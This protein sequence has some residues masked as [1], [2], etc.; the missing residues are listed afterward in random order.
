MSERLVIIGGGPAGVAAAR[1]YRDNGG[2][3]EVVILSEDT[4]LPYERPPLSKDFLRGS[5]DESELSIEE[6][7][8]YTDGSIE[9]RLGVKVTALNTSDHL[10]SLVDEDLEYGGC[11]IATGAGAKTLPV[12]GASHPAIHTLRSLAD[13]RR[14]RESV[15][16]ISRVAVLGSGFIGCEIA[17]SLTHQKLEVT[18]ISDEAVPHAARLGSEVGE[19]I[20]GWLRSEG[21]RLVLGNAVSQIEDGRSIVLEGGRRINSD[22]I[23]VAGGAAPRT[24]LATAAGI[25]VHDG[26]IWVDEYMRT[27]AKDVYAAGDVALAHNV[28]AQR[29]LAVEHW[30]EALTMGEIAGSNAAGVP[31]HW[32]NAPGF[33]STIGDRT[34]KYAG[35]GDGHDECRLIEHDGGAFTAWYGANGVIVGV[36]T[37]ECDEDYERGSA[38]IESAALLSAVP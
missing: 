11:V 16:G 2:N 23:V 27:S 8:F 18:L 38:L 12:P 33:W 3:A 14:L 36:L 31:A 21:C 26:R 24:E 20:A 5:V 22:L 13:A 30:G 35:W 6:P 28:T 15:T 7:E 34:L 10:V 4:V 29:L 32:D 17:A 9:M 37:Y 25:D 19:L 1:A